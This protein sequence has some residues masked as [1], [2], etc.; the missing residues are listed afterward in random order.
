MT[1]K[2]FY[3][4][5]N[6]REISPKLE[7]KYL[8]PSNYWSLPDVPCNCIRGYSNLLGSLS[9]IH[10]IYLCDMDQTFNIILTTPDQKYSLTA[11]YR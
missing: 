10:N 1:K 8:A 4:P 11:L 7:G 5:L 2:E 3:F 9:Y 6:H